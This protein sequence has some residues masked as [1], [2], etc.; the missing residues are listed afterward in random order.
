MARTLILK[1]G[2]T[3][4]GLSFKLK[5]EP[6][7]QKVSREKFEWN[8]MERGLRTKYKGEE[9][10]EIQVQRGKQYMVLIQKKDS[11]KG[12]SLQKQKFVWQK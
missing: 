5:I 6:T 4:A 8:E 9:N 2:K 7:A 3:Q 10:T 12:I 1:K 11:K